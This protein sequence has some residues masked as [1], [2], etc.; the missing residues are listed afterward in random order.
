M[1]LPHIINNFSPF[2]YFDA[3]EV[4]TI[5]SS[6][7][8]TI[9]F[10][11]VTD[12][13]IFPFETEMILPVNEYSWIYVIELHVNDDIRS[14]AKSPQMHFGYLTVILHTYQISSILISDSSSC[15]WPYLK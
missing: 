6:P 7:D 8:K 4:Y 15:F 5:T 10:P 11:F 3:L 2:E 9:P 12:I 1:P 14:V 13:K